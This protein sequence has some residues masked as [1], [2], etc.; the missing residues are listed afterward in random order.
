MEIVGYDAGGVRAR[1]RRL[2]H[3]ALMFALFWWAQGAVCLIPGLAHAHSG[4]AEVS[5]TEHADHAAHGHHGV[6]VPD[7]GSEP[8]PESDAGCEQHCAS[9]AQAVSP[10]ASVIPWP[11]ALWLPHRPAETHLVVQRVAARSLDLHH[12]PPPPD[13]VI[14]HVAL[15][16]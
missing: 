10:A 5:G 14:T 15:L 13:F 4:S 11:S 7:D 6:S 8:T 1:G 2:K 3:L 9:L 16:I 12:N